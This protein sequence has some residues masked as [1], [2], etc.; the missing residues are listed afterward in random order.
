MGKELVLAAAQ[1]GIR[2]TVLLGPVD[3]QVVQALSA[4]PIVRYQTPN[5][6]QQGLETL[7]PS[8]EVFFSAAAVL[9]FQTIP[10]PLKWS[11]ESL[12]E[13]LTLPISPVPDFAAWAGAHKRAHQK[14]ISFAAESGP[15][16]HCLERAEEKLRKKRSD[17]VILNPVTETTGPDTPTN[18]IWVLQPN[19]ARQ[20]LG[21]GT[22]QALAVKI[23]ETLFPETTPA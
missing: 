4:F 16:E 19:E 3:S 12:G 10:S 20:Y 8:C 7:F 15:T 21:K 22:K 11:R 23:L 9:D 2:P 1:R 17:A 14:V 13:S 5:E 6:Y 18:E